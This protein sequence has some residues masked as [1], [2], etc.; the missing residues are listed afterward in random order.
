[1]DLAL[2]ASVK[3]ARQIS[4]VAALHMQ[5]IRQHEGLR[6]L[7]VVASTESLTA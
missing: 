5:V 1:M 4:Q 2:M 6:N 3:R 7:A